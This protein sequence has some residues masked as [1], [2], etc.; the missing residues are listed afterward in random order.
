MMPIYVINLPRDAQRWQDMAQR[1]AGMA[2]PCARV[3]AVYGHDL[4]PPQRAALYD[5]AAN[6]QRYFQ[7]LQPGEIGCYASHLQVWQRLLDSGAPCALV[8]EDDIDPGATLPA[9]LQALAARPRGWDMVKLIGRDA[10]QPWRRWPLATGVSLIRY[11][12]L[13]SL[14]G[15]YVLSAAGAR[16]LLAARQPFFRP[17]DVDLRY[18]WE[19]G[20]QVYGAYPYPMRHAPA[21]ADSSIGQRQRPAGLASRW[22]KWRGQLAYTAMAVWANWRSRH[23]QPFSAPAGASHPGAPR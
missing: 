8:L 12:R 5:T 16:K 17:I 23:E 22:H 6:R 20:L 9:V 21:S 18:W 15:A 10:E 14:T 1:L 19:C 7:P 13:P 2:L 4:S 11:R 3:D